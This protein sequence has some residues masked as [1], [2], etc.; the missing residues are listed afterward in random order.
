[1]INKVVIESEDLAE[2]RWDAKDE[3]LI[4]WDSHVNYGVFKICPYGGRVEGKYQAYEYMLG[5]KSV[6]CA[7]GC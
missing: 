5:I 6:D 1:M 7:H 2:L 3:N 4:A